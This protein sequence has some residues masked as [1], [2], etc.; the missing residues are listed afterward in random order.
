MKKN[1]VYFVADFH[2]GSPDKASSREREK[3]VLAWLDSI[4][5]SAREIY[6]LGD[7]FDFWFE[8]KDLIPK[9]QTR[10]LGK[11]A[12]MADRG[13]RIHFFCG[14]H[15]MW[16]RDYLEEELGFVLHKTKEII[17]IDGQRFMIGHGDGLD[18]KDKK[19]KLI[20]SLFKSRIC[21]GLFATLHPRLAFALGRFWSRKSRES[22][23]AKDLTDLK[24]EEPIYKYC[25]SVHKKLEIDYFIFG[26]RHLACDMHI[27][28]HARYINVGEWLNQSCFALWDGTCLELQ[29]FEYR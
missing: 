10:F 22:H 1:N 4:E 13:C 5:D 14:N 17:E 20:N 29:R 11:L 21:T 3:K 19:Y 23:S 12:Q 27:G 7:I 2:F 25:M 15:D 8:Y 24:Q 6:L 9:G 26:H 18:T 16:Q 28:D